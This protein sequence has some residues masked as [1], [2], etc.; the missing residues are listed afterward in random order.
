MAKVN[1]L[2]TSR[3]KKASQKISKMTDLAEKSSSGEL[4]S[5]SGVF[6]ITPLTESEEENLRN[7]LSEYSSEK[8][9]ISDDLTFLSSITSEVKA[10]N[11]Q[12]A[13]LHG[14]RIKRAQDILKKYRDGA[15]SS[16]LVSAYGNRQTPYN[17]LQYFELYM[18]IPKVLQDKVDTMPRQAVYTL[19]TRNCPKERKEE[20]IKGY[21]G[22]TKKELLMLIRDR[23]P[24]EQKD[25]RAPNVAEQAIL[26]LT[27]IE[28]LISGPRFKPSDRQKKRMQ[29]VLQSIQVK[30]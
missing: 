11:N 25:K 13:I 15:F 8:Q 26:E 5:F 28:K 19:A 29:E 1:D 12:A 23:F 14:E 24:L 16:W 3:F 27:R 4:S 30:L 7:L 20:V 18:S 9:D 17:F 22:E 21:K 2:L 6:R 10:I